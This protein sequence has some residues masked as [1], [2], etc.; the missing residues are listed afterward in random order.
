MAVGRV[1]TWIIFSRHPLMAVVIPLRRVSWLIQRRNPKA[2]KTPCQTTSPAFLTA[3]AASRWAGVWR[4]ARLR[5]ARWCFELLK[6]I[7]ETRFEALRQFG[8]LE[9]SYP[10]WFLI[11]K[12][13]TRKEAIEAYGAITDEEFGPRGGWKSVTFGDK[14]F[15]SRKLRAK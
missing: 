7:T 6:R 15:I 12:A 9:C 11:T 14:K 10:T 8:S 13:L 2:T 3:G 5:R 1:L 4:N